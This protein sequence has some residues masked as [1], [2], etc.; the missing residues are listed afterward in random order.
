[1]KKK[2][3]FIISFLDFRD[4]EY[5][6]PKEILV[7]FGVEIKTASNKEGVAIGSEG[8]EVK[9]D[10][11]VSNVNLDDFDA[12]IFVGGP[13]CLRGLDNEISYRI[14]KEIFAKDKVLAAICIAPVI[15]A[16]AGVLRMKKAT[17]WT[18]DMDK[19]AKNILE[20]NGTIYS[21]GQVIIDKKIITA[22]GPSA[23]GKFGETIIDFL[24]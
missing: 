11:L 22:S 5:F 3:L 1:M 12:V 4:E 20:Q 21:D 16:K 6:V 15:L 13:G 17:V 14:A 8:G 7:D 10:F 19:S 9:V 2:V 24:H 18:S 23:V